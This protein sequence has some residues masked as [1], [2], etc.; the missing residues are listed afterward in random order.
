[1]IDLNG[2]AF[3]ARL[4]RFDVRRGFARRMITLRLLARKQNSIRQSTRIFAK[5]N[6]VGGDWRK[7]ADRFSVLSCLCGEKCS[8]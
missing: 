8:S 3:A 4:C 5:Q 7:F 6:K 2:L 1:L